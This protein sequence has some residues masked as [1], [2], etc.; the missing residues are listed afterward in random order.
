MAMWTGPAC[1]QLG[2]RSADL[3]SVSS[4]S[5][6]C[7]VQT[8]TGHGVCPGGRAQIARAPT[9]AAASG[10]SGDQ[11]LA[12]SAGSNAS[13]PGRRLMQPSDPLCLMG[14]I[15][16]LDRAVIHPVGTYGDR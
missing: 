6:F 8:A 10:A 1:G 7:R 13:H 2:T 3:R 4:R 15:V 11:S 5:A 14:L 16:S 12:G 9:D